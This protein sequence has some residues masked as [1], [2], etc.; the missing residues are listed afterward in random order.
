MKTIAAPARVYTNSELRSEKASAVD[1][2]PPSTTE[3]A[4]SPAV[5]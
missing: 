1:A 3:A 5:A 2:M 4:A